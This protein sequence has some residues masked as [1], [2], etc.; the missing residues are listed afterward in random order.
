MCDGVHACESYV[1]SVQV[2][3]SAADWTVWIGAA[4]LGVS[5]LVTTS[6][7][8]SVPACAYA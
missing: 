2:R 6:K 1:K 3:G 7:C 8:K 4:L 5:L